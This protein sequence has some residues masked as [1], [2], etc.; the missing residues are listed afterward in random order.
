MAERK[1]VTVPDFVRFKARGERIVMVTAYDYPSAVYADQAGVDAIL[2]GDSLGMVVLGYADTLPVTVDEI[3]HHLKAVTRARPKAL[4]IA[5]L[6]FLSYQASPEEAFRA[7]GRM[8][9]EGGAGAVKLEGGAAVTETVR[10]LASAGVPVMGHLGL[11]P[12]SVRTFGGFRAQ[13]KTGEAARKLLEDARAL[14]EAGAFG[15][16]LEGIPSEVAQA[17]TGELHIPT[18]GIGAGP[19]CDGE[20]QVFHDLVGLHTG[21][22]PRHAKQFATLADTIREA[23]STYAVEVRAG[24]F[25]TEAQTLHQKDLEDP[26]SWKS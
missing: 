9:K 25:P 1:P 18:I 3:L 13:A 12:Q 19:H 26:S 15:I 24:G 6:P 21:F 23:L 2:V 11:T 5:D 20:V 7:A 4:V 16:V 22:V 17:V 10:R 14:E 8:L